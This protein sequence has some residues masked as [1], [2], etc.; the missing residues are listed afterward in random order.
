MILATPF[1]ESIAGKISQ[2]EMVIRGII[3]NSLSNILLSHF[4]FQN[5]SCNITDPDNFG[6][7]FSGKALMGN[8]L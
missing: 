1:R 4:Y 5:I 7:I 8:Y 6:N 3:S 2:E